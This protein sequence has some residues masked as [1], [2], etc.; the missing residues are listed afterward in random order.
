MLPALLWTEGILT[1][2]F[3]TQP[4]KAPE[5]LFIYFLM[6]QIVLGHVTFEMGARGFSSAE[7]APVEAGGTARAP[8]PPKRSQWCQPPE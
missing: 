2:I 5:S 8:Q 3:K 7:I 6:L 1:S 4:P